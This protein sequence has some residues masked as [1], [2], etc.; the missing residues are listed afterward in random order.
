MG[1][2]AARASM[3][4]SGTGRSTADTVPARPGPRGEG[5]F[6][7]LEML[8]ALVIAAVLAGTLMLAVPDRSRSLRYEADRLARLMAVAREEA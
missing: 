8:V 2:P 5:G 3:P 7:L 4:T 6:T 1:S